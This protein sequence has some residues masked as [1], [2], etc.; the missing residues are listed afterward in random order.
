MST[1]RTLVAYKDRGV[2]VLRAIGDLLDEV[3]HV[4][5]CAKD[6][7][8]AYLA[9]NQAACTMLG[10]TREELLAL[11]TSDVATYPE[12]LAQAAEV[13]AVEASLS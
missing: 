7:D 4:M 8:G 10:Y 9:V 11:K 3:P 6:R 12:A 1:V 5:F 2:E 13:D